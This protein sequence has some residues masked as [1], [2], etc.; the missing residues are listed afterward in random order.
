MTAAPRFAA[1][2]H[3]GLVRPV[4]EDSV[5]ALPE[6]GVWVVADGMGGHEAGD[7]ASA[8][9]TE[10]VAMIDADL[11]P[12]DTVRALRGALQYAHERI[13]HESAMRHGQTMGSTVVAL[14]IANGHFACLWSGD[15]RLYRLQ[16]GGLLSPLHGRA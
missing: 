3:P 8:I 4:N 11:T 16:N 13:Q 7:V 14:A 9:V 5:V 15:S 1:K 6:K 12:A 10:S 2:T